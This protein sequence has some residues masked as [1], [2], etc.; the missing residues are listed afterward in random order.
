MHICT[1]VQSKD[2]HESYLFVVTRSC[3]SSM[4]STQSGSNR[5]ADILTSSLALR[6]IRTEYYL[7]STRTTSGQPAHVSPLES[8]LGPALLRLKRGTASD[9]VCQTAP[10]GVVFSSRTAGLGGARRSCE[11][12]EL[13]RRF[14]WEFCLFKSTI[15]V[16]AWLYVFSTFHDS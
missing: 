3:E 13:I 10:S 9:R 16:F 7:Q 5:G 2:L 11:D 15:D 1:I 14:C 4:Y 12:T 6:S 8:P